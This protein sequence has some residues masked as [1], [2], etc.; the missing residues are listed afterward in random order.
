[1]FVIRS[2]PNIWMF[3]LQSSVHLGDQA[4]FPAISFSQNACVL[5]LGNEYGTP[6]S[7]TGLSPT[8]EEYRLAKE[9]GMPILPCVKGE[10]SFPRESATRA[11]FDEIKSDG[12]TYGRFKSLEDLQKKVRGRLVQH[13]ETIYDVTP[14]QEDNRN[15]ERNI[16]VADLFERQRLD[17]VRWEDVDR[18]LARTMVAAA[19]EVE[20][21]SLMDEDVRGQLLDRGYLWFDADADAYFATAA[22]ILLLAQDS[23]KAFPHARVQIDAYVGDERTA[24][25]DD[26]AFLRGPVIRVLDNAVQFVQRNTRHPMRVVGLRRVRVDEYPE[27]ALREALVNA[28]A[29]RDYQDAGLKVT[30]EVFHDRIVVTNPG[31]P[32]GGQSLA[33]IASG[34]GRS[35]SRNPL[36]AQGLAWLKAMEDRGTGIMRMTGAMLDHGL[37]RPAFALDQGCVVV[38]LPGPGDDLDR[39][40]ISKETPTGLTPAQ[41]EALSD[42]QRAILREAVTSGF[43]TTAWCIE[44][45]D[46]VKDTARRDF[47]HLVKLG[48]LQRVGKG[49]GTKYVPTLQKEESTDD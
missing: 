12:Y 21:E 44:A 26:Y 7:D 8:H 24:K 18:G 38:A 1:M 43:I 10:R 2:Y 14:G 15:A 6:A 17:V 28:I 4:L 16:T 36:L 9:L 13:V 32:P 19:E 46:I 23:S 37:D 48:L 41:E 39:I 11:L 31:L 3:Y 47:R 45:F 35:R 33:H 27:T 30:F 22:G 40:R 29:H 25:A 20:P 49:R 5:I 42:R 34:K